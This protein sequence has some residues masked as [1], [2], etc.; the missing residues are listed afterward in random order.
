MKFLL[1]G[2]V[3][4][5]LFTAAQ[6]QH[7]FKATIRG[8]ED[9]SPLPGAS[10]TWKNQ[11]KTVIADSAGIVTITG[12]PEG[13]QQ[14]TV[15]FVGY[16][17]QDLSYIFPLANQA[18]I[19]IILEH[20]EEEEDEEAVIV[21]AT[22]TSRTI[23]NTPTRTE[24]IS[25]EELGEKGNMKPGDIRMLLNE[26]TGIQTQQTSATSFNAGIRIQ[27]L[28][29]RYTQLLRD[30]YPL[31]A[32]F[33][34]GLSILQIAPLD[35]Q[36][37]EVIKGS[38]STLYGGGAIA[39]LVNLVSKKPGKERELNFMANG[40]SARG[41]DLSGFYSERYGKAGLT[42]FASRNSNAPF[43]PADIGLTAIP[44][45]ERYTINPRLFLYGKKLTADV[46]VTYITEDRV[47]GN[48]NYIKHGGSGFYEKNNTDRITTQLGVAYRLND[49]STL[50][51]KNSYS[52]FNRDIAIPAYQFEA[53]Q[54][55][56]FSELTWNYKGEQSDWV[57]GANFLTDDLKEEKRS[58]DPLRDYHYNTL[59]FFVQ[60]AWTVSERLVLET[61]L[62]GDYVKEYG[63]ELLPRVAAMLRITPR[64]TTRLGGG[65]G[66]KTPTV[67][68]EES[69]RIQFQHVLPID[70][71]Q[72]K[73]ERSVGGNWD[74]N[75]R[76]NI[77]PVNVSFNHLFFYTRLNRP[78]VLEQEGSGQLAFRNSTGYI[79]TRGME[80]NL[81]LV[82]QDFKLFIGYT[83]TDANTHFSGKEQ[84]LPLTARHRLNN[85][86]MY[87]V[88]DKLKLGLEAYYFSRQQL[89]DGNMGKDYWI[90][91]F[92]AEKLWEKF[93]L[94][95]NF[96][97]FTNTRQSRF[98]TIYTGTI[99]NPVFRDIYAPVEGFVVNGGVKIKL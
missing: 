2:I 85:V 45:F 30:G 61:G 41:L 49:Q 35:L 27:G 89:S 59:G 47:G 99:D 12:I 43:D 17:A 91:G 7:I 86:L 3:L 98:D 83:Y 48:V 84:W 18:A 75:Y 1:T 21:T 73:N 39:G 69:E 68:T 13:E 76:T 71:N 19:E 81:R 42:V 32:G 52:H 24:V 65:F 4:C 10:I 92:M 8:G 66:Y 31:Y 26:S 37:V 14:F 90:T 60:N 34:G 22:R 67:F 63:F 9:K 70:V 15:S 53:L 44:K 36:Q 64:L 87:E 78:L 11:Q 72:S 40:T 96:E 33:S 88:E 28:D 80:T 55:S 62:R 6:A 25:G 95:I 20:A 23:A 74:F 82:Y 93:S 50:Q 38:A 58:A 94:F 16:E 77:G 29:G 51:F 97:N 46:G 54:Q 57:I 79:D 5:C 56:S